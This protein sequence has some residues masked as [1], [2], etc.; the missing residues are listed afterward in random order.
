MKQLF[1]FAA[2]F[3]FGLTGNLIAQEYQSNWSS[4]ITV[5][6]V[7]DHINVYPYSDNHNYLYFNADLELASTYGGHDCC[8]TSPLVADHEDQD[9]FVVYF[10]GWSNAVIDIITPTFADNGGIS[11]LGLTPLVNKFGDKWNEIR[12]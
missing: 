11:D 12:G 8:N 6:S 10:S 5:P 1:S 4:S 2:L 3:V 9:G 7:G